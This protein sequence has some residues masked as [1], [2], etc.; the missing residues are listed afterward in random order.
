MRHTARLFAFILIVSPAAMCQAPAASSSAAATDKGGFTPANLDRDVDPCTDFYQYACGTWRKNNPIPSDQAR[1]G[2]FNELAE[3]NRQFL[4]NILEKASAN[5]PKRT[6]VM[7]KIGDM[8]ESC[9]DE[10]SV[11]KKGSAPLK[12]ELARIAA[13]TNKDQLLETIAYRQSPRM[14]PLVGFGPTS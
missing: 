14:Q 1:W 6:P 3:Y 4:H 10:A 12:P 7:Q 13:I 8:Y 2:R 9:M 11:N 5:D